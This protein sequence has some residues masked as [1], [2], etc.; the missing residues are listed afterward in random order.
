MPVATFPASPGSHVEM[1]QFR[2][3]FDA[4]ANPSRTLLYG[5]GLSISLDGRFNY[6]SLRAPVVARLNPRLQ[7]LLNRPRRAP[8]VDVEQLFLAYNEAVNDNNAL[9]S[10]GLLPLHDGVRDAIQVRDQLLDELSRAFLTEVIDI[11]RNLRSSIHRDKLQRVASFL[12]RFDR[13][14]TLNYDLLWLLLLEVS[15]RPFPRPTP[16]HGALHF[17]TDRPSGLFGGAW[18]YA[19]VE[20]S[21]ASG[22][23]TLESVVESVD[24]AL[25]RGTMPAIVLA[26]TWLEKVQKSHH[27]AECVGA[28]H[29][30]DSLRQLTGSLYTYGWSATSVSRDFLDELLATAERNP[31]LMK[32]VW[33][34]GDQHILDAIAE[35]PKLKTLCM[36]VYSSTKLP[37]YEAIGRYVARRRADKGY[38]PLHMCFFAASTAW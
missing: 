35:A 17:T 4:D 16:L 18:Q 11:H 34:P 1:L 36:G 23:E 27:I 19:E 5:N 13:S 25:R 38:P 21:A 32:S 7:A 28:A 3:L 37:D 10:A 29:D 22:G 14:Y 24:D 2:E 31:G 33:I 15:E 30:V 20:D 12:R 6:R 26:S 8:Q 9:V